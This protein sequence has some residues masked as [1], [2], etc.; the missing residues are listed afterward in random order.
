[1]KEFG[2]FLRHYKTAFAESYY[3]SY[4]I[5]TRKSIFPVILNKALFWGPSACR[6]GGS[7]ETS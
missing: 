5:L 4:Y 7:G 2:L 1:M 6:R 3:E